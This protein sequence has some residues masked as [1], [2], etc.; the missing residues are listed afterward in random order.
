MTLT[1]SYAEL[2]RV[3]LRLHRLGHFSAIVGWDRNAMMPHKGNAARAAA[4]AELHALIH[5][6]RTEPRLAE[7]LQAA[8][9]EALT[10]IESANLREMRR[11]WRDANALRESL[12]EARTLAG[13]RCE[14]AWRSQR[15]AN[16]WR[17]FLVNFRE[18]VRL[19]RE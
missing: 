17:V 11:D 15:P 18:V 16:D 7:L 3:W 2:C 14:H 13:A 10:D 1:P 9:Q 4:E 8:A 12:V 19:A 6:T 5:R